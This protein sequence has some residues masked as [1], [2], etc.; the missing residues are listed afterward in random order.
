MS[1]TDYSLIVQLNVNSNRIQND[2]VTFLHRFNILTVVKGKVN[3]VRKLCSLKT[4]R[5]VEV[6]FR[7]LLIRHYGG[8][9]TEKIINYFWCTGCL[10]ENHSSL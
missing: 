4:Y 9:Y 1:W 6:E 2:S 10:D 7:H 3:Y 8:K 5:G